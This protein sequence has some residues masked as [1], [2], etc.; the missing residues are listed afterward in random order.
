MGLSE[1]WDE[2]RSHIPVLT[3][4]IAIVVLIMNII[5]PGSGTLLFI[6]L[7]INKNYTTEYLI[8]GL[9]QFVLTILLVGWIW[10]IIWGIFAL[11]KSV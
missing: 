9:L 8:V 11:Q 7:G 10:S 5:I 1:K 2:L 6:C 4:G 3:K